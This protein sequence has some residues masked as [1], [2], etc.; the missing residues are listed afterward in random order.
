MVA[1]IGQSQLLGGIDNLSALCALICTR[2][3]INFPPALLFFL[4]VGRHSAHQ[5]LIPFDADDS[6]SAL[7][8]WLPIASAILAVSR[9]PDAIYLTVKSPQNDVLKNR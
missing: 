6:V 7:N 1:Q 2:I 5:P 8:R 3:R 9:L 4:P